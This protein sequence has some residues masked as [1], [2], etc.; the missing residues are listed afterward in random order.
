VRARGSFVGSFV[1][2]GRPPIRS[3]TGYF[4]IADQTGEEFAMGMP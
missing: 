1:P 3:S 4:L 2:P